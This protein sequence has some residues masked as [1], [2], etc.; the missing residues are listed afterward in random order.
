MALRKGYGLDNSQHC[1]RKLKVLELICVPGKADAL[2]YCFIRSLLA[3][4]T[5]VLHDA[6]FYQIFQSDGLNDEE[7]HASVLTRLSKLRLSKLPELTHIW[8]E[9]FRAAFCNLRIL[10]AEECG[11]FK[12][13]VPSLASFENL[14]TLEVSRCHGIFN[15]IACSEAK[16]LI[17]LERLSI[18]DC[19][20]IEEIIACEGEEIKGGIVFIKLKYLQLSCLPSLVSFSLG[21]H[22]FEFPALEKV[23]LRKCPKMKNFCQGDLSTPKLER[24]QFTEDEDEDEKR[25]RWDG[26]LKTTIQQLFKEM[27]IQN[28]EVVEVNLQL[29]N[30][31]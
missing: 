15:L 7:R 28:S 10:E 18:T 24:V 11:K 29:P 4:E 17:L 1:F 16:S 19:K 25:G 9:E 14:T 23:I 22:N 20:M 13:L 27:N 8:Q 3:L 31:E 21:D 5:L 30:L 2:P 12:T 6:S 26:N